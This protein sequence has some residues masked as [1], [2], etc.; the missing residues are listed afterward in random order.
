MIHEVDG[1]YVI[2][3]NRGWIPGFYA[4]ERTAKYAFKFKSEELQK[5]TD[6][7]APNPITFVMLQNLR[8][9]LKAVE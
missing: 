9:K 1:G 6:E 4:D 3:S 5:L 7:V 8:Q 2:S